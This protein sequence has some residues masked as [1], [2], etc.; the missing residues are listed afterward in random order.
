MSVLLPEPLE[1][2]SAVVDPA[3][4]TNETSRSTS[5]PG[6]VLERHVLELDVTVDG[7]H[8]L[9]T[10]VGVILGGHVADLANA[11]EP[12]NASL[13]CVPMD[14][15]WTSGTAISPRRTRTTRSR[16][17][18]SFPARIGPPPKT[19]ITTPI[20]PVITAVPA[21]TADVPVIVLATLRK[22]LCTPAR[23]HQPL[24]RLGDVDLHETD[25]AD[26]F[27]ESAAHLGV[28]LSA[29][30]KQRTQLLEGARHHPA[31]GDEHEQHHRRELPIEIEE[32]AERDKRL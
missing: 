3:G 7:R 14:A 28:D 15:I 19:I 27:G 17:A 32:H 12:A 10:G 9:F 31:E 11:I 2:T 20:I 21:A 8:C 4:A 26:C 24:P 18:S 13:T 22:S 29:L 30:A 25:A 23:E 1:P 5:T 6:T 16:P